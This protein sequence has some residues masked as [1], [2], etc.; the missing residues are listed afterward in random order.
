VRYLSNLWKRLARRKTDFFTNPKYRPQRTDRFSLNSF[1]IKINKN[2]RATLRKE[3]LFPF[4]RL[5]QPLFQTLLTGFSS[6][7]GKSVVESFQS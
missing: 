6:P 4:A 7:V 2:N 1:G 3:S 5:F